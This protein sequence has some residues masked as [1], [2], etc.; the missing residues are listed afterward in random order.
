MPKLKDD[1]QG[2]LFRYDSSISGMSHS[3]QMG[4]DRRKLARRLKVGS[5][6]V[7]VAEPSNPVDQDAILIYPADDLKNDIGYLYSST[8]RH[9][10]K[11]LREGATFAAE[12]TEIDLNRPKYPTYRI[13]VYQ[14]TNAANHEAKR[15]SDEYYRR[16]QS[17]NGNEIYIP[18]YHA[19]MKIPAP[20]HP[21]LKRS[22]WQR[23]FG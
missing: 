15:G 3:N 18:A 8:A 10:A 1:P 19:P 7:L 12:I 9:V 16:A 13:A 5:Q 21:P 17:Y 11:K 6:L 23:L 14:L 22:W 4:R 20:Q 2:R